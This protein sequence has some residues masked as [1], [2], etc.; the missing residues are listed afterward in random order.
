V[1]SGAYIFFSAMAASKKAE[2][3]PEKPESE[4]PG[5]QLDVVKDW[6]ESEVSFRDDYEL[7]PEVLGEGM[8][9]SVMKAVHRATGREGWP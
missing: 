3:L 5:P 2:N 8:C 1:P 6:H 4:A 9:G 7:T